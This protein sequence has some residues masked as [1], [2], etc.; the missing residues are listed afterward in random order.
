MVWANHDGSVLWTYCRARA[1]GPSSNDYWPYEI[2]SPVPVFSFQSWHQREVRGGKWRC[3]WIAPSSNG[4]PKMSLD[5]T[6]ATHPSRPTLTSSFGVWR[7]HIL[8]RYAV[9]SSKIKPTSRRNSL[10]LFPCWFLLDWLLDPEEGSDML[11][12]NLSVLS[13]DYKT[14]RPYK[15]I[16]SARTSGTVN[17]FMV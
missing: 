17:L 2:L 7:L 6:V 15:I 3:S 14:L 1:L 11:L 5:S 16:I 4:A 8:G 9:K 12:R 13:P 10:P